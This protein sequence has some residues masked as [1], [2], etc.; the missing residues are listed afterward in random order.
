LTVSKRAFA[1]VSKPVTLGW[2]SNPLGSTSLK[3]IGL[4]Y[5]FVVTD[6]LSG[7]PVQKVEALSGESSAFSDEQGKIK[8]TVDKDQEKIEVQFKKQGIRTEKVTATDTKAEQALKLVPS[9][10]HVFITKRSGK[11]DVYKVDVDGK[12][13]KL[14]LAGTG[15]ERDDM[16]LVPH[17]GK[18]LAVLVSTRDGKRNSDGFQ[19]STLTIIDLEDD[20]ISSVGQSERIQVVDWAGDRLVYVQIAAGTS[21]ANPKRHRLMSYSANDESNKEIATSNYFNDVLF[22]RGKLYYAPSSAYQAGVNV[23][24]F[25]SDP[26]GSN[27]QVIFGEEVWNAFRTSYDHLVLSKDQKWYDYT[28]GSNSKPSKMDGAPANL[29]NRL[30]VDSLD[31]DRSLWT[32]TRDGKGVLLSYD[33]GAKKDSVLKAQSGLKN[34][35]YWLNDQVVVYRVNTPNETADYVMSL[36]GGD[37]RKIRDVSDTGGIDKWYYY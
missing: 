8:L 32:E 17:P 24:F 37:A 23:S 1:E 31:G 28:I 15:K 18:D 3:P 9:R 25:S 22:A 12:N 5:S 14:V 6:W 21:A 13:E 20:S 29:T 11:Y 16:V 10:K 35:I 7:K 33:I 34:P 2:G 30:Y 4:Q 26:D 19:L 27:R 36:D